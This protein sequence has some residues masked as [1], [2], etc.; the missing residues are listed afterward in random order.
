MPSRRSGRRSTVVSKVLEGVRLRPHRV[1]LAGAL[2]G[3]LAHAGRDLPQPYLMGLT[4]HAFR[5]TLDVVISPGSPL[6]LNFHEVFPLWE[7]VGAWWGRAGARPVAEEFAQVRGEVLRRVADTVEAGR[8]A[9]AFDLLELPEYGLVTGV[10]GDRWACLTLDSPDEPQWMETATWPPEAHRQFTRAEAIWL[11]DLAPDFD[12]RRAEVASLRFAVEHFWSPPSRDMWLQH[13]G[14]AYE[15]W[16]SSLASSLPLHGVTP[17]LGHS[18]NL[19][20]LHAARR[21]AASYLTELAARY[22]EAPS[23]ATAATRFGEVTAIAEEA[24][25]IL[26]FPG[27]DLEKVETRLAVA[28]CLRRALAA[29]RAGIDEIERS[30]RVLR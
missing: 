22:P 3:L 6:E 2:G 11:L 10:D 30:F 7:N 13:G 18:F 15:F 21:D 14:K 20:V 17:G 1:T 19:L 26:P 24:L 5:L 4:G 9:I 8:P 16:A 23:L 27:G 25:T 12:R 28:N 29:E